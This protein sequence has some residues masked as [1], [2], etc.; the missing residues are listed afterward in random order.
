MV[1]L[2]KIDVLVTL[3]PLA[4]AS[5]PP[6]VLH[7]HASQFPVFCTWYQL[8]LEALAA[9]ALAQNAIRYRADDGSGGYRVACCAAIACLMIGDFSFNTSFIAKTLSSYEDKIVGE[10]C[11][12]LFI[13]VLIAVCGGRFKIR[14][15]PWPCQLAWLLVALVLA[16]AQ[17][18]FLMKPLDSTYHYFST[19]VRYNVYFY[20]FATAF[21]TPLLVLGCLKTVDKK[22]HAWLQAVLALMVLDF[23][24]RYQVANGF[25]TT[26]LAQ[27]LWAGATGYLCV[28]SILSCGDRHAPID[29]R[30]DVAAWRSARF[31]RFRHPHC[32]PNLPTWWPRIIS[33]YARRKIC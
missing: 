10:V 13:I 31:I 23:A 29:P 19:A 6:L 1:L 3:F 28:L 2:K 7:I 27:A 25:A 21:L 22:E 16:A 14:A 5:L 15:A 17:Y 18:C 20:G 8:V 32:F 4:I 26:T 12:S 11:Y 33:Y 30:R 24:A 9:F